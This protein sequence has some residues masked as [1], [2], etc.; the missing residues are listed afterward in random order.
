VSDIEHSVPDSLWQIA[1][2]LILPAPTRPHGGGRVVATRD[3]N[4]QNRFVSII[5]I[6]DREIVHWRDY[7]DPIAVF[8]AMG[9]PSAR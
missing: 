5:T 8:D 9:W 3:E 7:L 1:A 4:Y 2:A 6:K